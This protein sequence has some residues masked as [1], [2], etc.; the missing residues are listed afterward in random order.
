MLRCAQ[1]DSMVT[2]AASRQ[3]HPIPI[4]HVTLSRSEGSPA[5]GTE[6]LP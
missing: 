3:N 1:H 6:M 4:I 2:H 5:L